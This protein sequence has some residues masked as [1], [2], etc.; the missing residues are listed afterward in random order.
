M[1]MTAEEFHAWSHRLQFTSETE[2]LIAAMRSSPPVRRVS[3]RAK[4]ITGRYPSPKMQCSIQFESEHVEFWAIYTMERDDDVLEFYDQSSRIPLS[5]RAKSGRKTTQWHTPDFFVLRRQSAGWEEWKPAQSLDQLSDSMPARYQQTGTGQWRCPPGEEYAEPLGLSYRLR[6]SAEFHPL[7]IQNL[8]FLQDFWAHEVPPHWEQE[9]LALAH[10]QVHPGIPLTELLDAYPDLPVDVVWLLLST[11]RVFTDLS[12]TLLMRH[13]RVALYAEESQVE[14][15]RSAS[16]LS[17]PVSPPA[18]PLAWDGRLWMI[19]RLADVVQLRPEVG[20]LLTL[21]RAEFEYLQQEGSLW[22]VDSASPSPITPEVRQILEH[23]SP[24]AQQEA[25]RRL[26][27]MLVYARGEPIAAPRRSVQRWW[28]AYRSAEAEYGCGYLGLLDRVAARGNRTPR[29]PDASM[30]LLEAHL[31]THYAAP[32]AKSAAAVYRLYRKDCGRQGLPP[33]SE[34]TFYRVRAR[35]TTTDVIG[36]RRGRRAAYAAQPFSWLDQTTPRH[37]ERPFA[38][39]HLD[40][41]ELDIELVSSVTGKS[42]GKPWATFLTDANTRRILACY[43]TFDPPSYRSVMMAF[44]ECV[45]RHQRL[46]QE[47]FVDRGPEFGSVYFETLLTR[48]FVTKKDRPASHPRM[49]SVVERLFGTATTQLLHQLL[50]NTQVSKQPRLMTREVDPKRLAVWTLDRFSARLC[51]YAYEVYDQ[52]DHPA[53]GQS[54]REAFA[55]GMQLAGMRLHRL[56]PYSEEFLL[57]TC[58]STRTGCAKLDGAR[59]IVVNGLRYWNPL[60]R[61]SPEAGRCVPVRYEPFDMSIAYAFVD[62]QWL[63]CTADAFFQVQGRSEREWQLILDEW[64]A[65]QRQHGRK[66]V[67]VDGPLLAQFLEEIATEEQ[68]LLQRQR[69]LEGLPVREAIVGQRSQ[70]LIPKDTEVQ[71]DDEELDLAALP[72]LEEYR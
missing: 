71:E 24:R 52:L 46:P 1:R 21:P 61:S 30:Q 25:N 63:K 36:A 55:Q 43:V 68:L 54:P 60:M 14:A 15:P 51:Q 49:G 62:G 3:G 45:K 33:V 20:E 37:G 69:D 18:T 66:R 39:A 4:N 47:C 64:R 6:S 31:R 42:L 16:S 35:F 9:A 10:I 22:V 50:G 29:I 5:Y 41:T 34:R 59:G 40:H 23:A 17:P 32:Q 26:T 57:L 28:R 2:A 70:V 38:L 67:S 8:K 44:R 53:L 65:Q 27:Q 12:A 72:K 13:D 56:I 11:R 58:P 7:E 48:Y 19:E